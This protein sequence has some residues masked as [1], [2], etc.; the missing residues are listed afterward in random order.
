MT[1]VERDATGIYGSTAKPKYNILTYTWGR[2]KVRDN[3]KE[4]SALPVKGTPWKIPAV[5]GEHFTVAAFQNVSNSMRED[6][7]D[8]IWVD[9]ACID[10][11]DESLN[12]DEVG[13]QA[14]I[15]KRADTAYV[16][17][18]NLPTDT[19]QEIFNDLNII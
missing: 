11:E 10:Q 13:R 12:A 9:V 7:I 14:S 8:W 17:L 2:W 19:L 15:F 3:V 4:H 18:S 5:R 6:G 1:S 16:C